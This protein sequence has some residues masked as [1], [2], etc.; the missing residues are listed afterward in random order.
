MP[1]MSRQTAIEKGILAALV[2]FDVFDYPLTKAE[3]VRWFFPQ[4]PIANATREEVQQTLEKS[5]RLWSFMDTRDNW[6]FI[7]GRD[8]LIALRAERKKISGH[9]W[10]IARFAAGLL[11]VVPFLRLV[12]VSNTLALDNARD[13]SDIDFFIISRSHRLWTM[14]F[15]ATVLLDLA[16]LR[17]KGSAIKDKIC[18][19]FYV[20][21]DAINLEPLRLRPE[22]PYLVFWVNQLVPLIDRADFLKFQQAN[23]WTDEFLP[24]ASQSPTGSLVRNTPVTRAMKGL[25][26][27]ML[28]GRFGDWLE[29]KLKQIQKKKMDHNTQSVAWEN[30][31]KVI[32]SDDIL[33]FHEQDRRDEY[34]RRFGERFWEI[35]SRKP[36]A[37]N[38]RD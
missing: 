4:E 27:R 14:R 26:E 38:I 1:V 29:K 37:F 15:L 12:A 36:G 23:Q 6:Y 32:I 33:K 11:Q 22:D 24:F 25:A 13:S 18:L 34:R 5:E 35:L 19:S 16:R 7:K 9:K 2:Y 31:T 20:T 21:R 30:N 10:R 17:R 8:S 3:L 28:S